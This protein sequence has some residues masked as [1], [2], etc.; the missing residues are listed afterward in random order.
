MEGT[1]CLSNSTANSTAM[2]SY[3]RGLRAAME[4][5]LGAPV[6][7]IRITGVQVRNVTATTGDAEV[8][9]ALPAPFVAYDNW[10][11]YGYQDGQ[12]KVTNCHAP[13]GGESTSASAST[14]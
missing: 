12:W 10:V 3:L 14:P 9:Y 4:H 1:P 13:I 11:S 5:Y 6:G 7:S 2:E 8:H